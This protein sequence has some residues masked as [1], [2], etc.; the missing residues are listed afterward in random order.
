MISVNYNESLNRIS[1]DT[2]AEIIGVSNTVKTVKSR[3]IQFGKLDTPVLIS[4]ESGTGKELVARAIHKNSRRAD[5]PFIAV[6]WWI[7]TSID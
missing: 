3:I 2:V 1:D 7:A 4:G 6:N 5:K